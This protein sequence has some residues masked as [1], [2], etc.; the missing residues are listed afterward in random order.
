MRVQRTSAM[1][2][3]RTWDGD[4]ENRLFGRSK[5][6]TRDGAVMFYPGTTLSTAGLL[7]TLVEA[8][9]AALVAKV[10]ELPEK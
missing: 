4:D 10:G 1:S 5:A 3:K 6:S 7:V 8:E 9:R 2:R